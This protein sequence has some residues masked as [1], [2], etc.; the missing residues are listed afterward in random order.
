[1]SEQQVPHQ[2]ATCFAAPPG[3]RMK[4]QKTTSLQTC[5]ANH[6]IAARLQVYLIDYVDKTSIVLEPLSCRNTTAK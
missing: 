5:G 6:A 4:G 2:A 1:M 3:H